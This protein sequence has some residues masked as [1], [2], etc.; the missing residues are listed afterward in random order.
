M[1]RRTNRQ[2]DEDSQVRTEFDFLLAW[3]VMRLYLVFSCKLIAL[4]NGTACRETERW[5]GD[6]FAEHILDSNQVKYSIVTE[7]GASIY[8]CGDIAKKEF[9]DLDVNL[10]SAGNCCQNC[11]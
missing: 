9:P 10:I 5:I 2:D 8:S 6:L 11:C 3:Y 7:Q 4:G 1:V